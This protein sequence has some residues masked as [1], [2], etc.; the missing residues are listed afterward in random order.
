MKYDDL[1]RRVLE[2]PVLASDGNHSA[3]LWRVAENVRDH[4]NRHSSDDRL[5]HLMGRIGVLCRSLAKDLRSG[6]TSPDQ[7]AAL[8]DRL[9]DLGDLSKEQWRRHLE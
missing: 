4:A 5:L 6:H 3:R 9:A 2:N 7:V 1:K 8:L